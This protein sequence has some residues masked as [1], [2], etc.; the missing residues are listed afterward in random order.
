MFDHQNYVLNVFFS[1]KNV[2]MSIP[3]PTHTHTHST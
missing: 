3:P 1:L 2:Q